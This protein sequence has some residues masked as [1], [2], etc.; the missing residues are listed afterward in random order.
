[1]AKLHWSTGEKVRKD[2]LA[3]GRGAC[4]GQI[5][6]ALSRQPTGDYE[7]GVNLALKGESQF[8]SQISANITIFRQVVG[9]DGPV[10]SMV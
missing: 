10:N 7:Y 2:I 5:V 1:M 6:R 3:F 8:G 9:L 4:G